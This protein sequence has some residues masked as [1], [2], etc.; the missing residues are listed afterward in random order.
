M[1]TEGNRQET[2]GD[3]NYTEAEIELLDWAHK[4]LQYTAAALEHRARLL[5]VCQRL[6]WVA[7]AEGPRSTN[8]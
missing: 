3:M 4:G 6:G 5:L 7:V 1:T 2:E 8:H